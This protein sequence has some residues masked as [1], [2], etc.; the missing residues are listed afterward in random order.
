MTKKTAILILMIVSILAGGFVLYMIFFYDNSPANQLTENGQVRRI[1]D[2]FPRSENQNVQQ[3]PSQPGVDVKIDPKANRL[4]LIT[5]S[6][7][8]GFMLSDKVAT[9]TDNEQII[10]TRYKYIEKATG[11]VFEAN[12]TSLNLQRITNTTIPRIQEAIFFNNGNSVLLRYLNQ[13]RE[14]ETFVGRILEKDPA[15]ISTN[16]EGA[17]LLEIKGVFLTKDIDYITKKIGS[18]MFFYTKE[19]KGYTFDGKMPQDQRAILD[20]TITEFISEWNDAGIILTTKASGLY[21]SFVFNLS[22]NGGQIRNIIS[23][24]NGITTKSNR[25]GGK[26]F[27]SSIFGGRIFN[28]IYITNTSEGSLLLSQTFAEKCVWSNKE[29]NILYCAQPKRIPSG[30]MPDSWYQGIVSTDDEII[31]INTD[32]GIIEL[33]ASFPIPLDVIEP[34]LSENENYLVFMNKS[35]RTLWSLYIGK[36]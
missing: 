35:D 34:Q 32:T 11:N 6:S 31:K 19:G 24:L 3:Q 28:N 15:E 36:M 14:I 18:D 25:S 5:E 29:Q 8:A 7:V 27:Y 2:I 22:P 13:N 21:E 26:I 1:G 9:T 10:E 33:V 12:S 17:D 20:Q 30:V 4:R 23:G 16:E